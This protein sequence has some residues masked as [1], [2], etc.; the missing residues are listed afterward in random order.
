MENK[1]HIGKIITDGI[2]KKEMLRTVIARSMGVPNTN[3]YAFE[4]RP[5]LNSI[6]ILKL[7]HAMRH[8]FFR[9]IADLLP[10]DYTMAQTDPKEKIIAEQAETIRN[11]ERE[12]NL[13]KELIVKR[14]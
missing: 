10:A 2:E 14:G 4:K 3:I 11:L 7:C 5:S 9:D 8:N 6:N 12:N 13:L 1:I